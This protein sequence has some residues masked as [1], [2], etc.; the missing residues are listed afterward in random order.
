MIILLGVVLAILLVVFYFL[1]GIRKYAGGYQVKDMTSIDTLKARLYFNELNTRNLLQEI[2]ENP[3]KPIT[4]YDEIEHKIPYKEFDDVVRQIH[5]IGQ[6]KLFLTELQ[7]LTDYLSKFDEKVILVYSGSSPSHKMSY[8]SD[9]FPNLKVVMID[10]N[11]HEV[12]FPNNGSQYQKEYVDTAVYFKCAPGNRFKHNERLINLFDGK[13]VQKHVKRTPESIKNAGDAID[14]ALRSKDTKA[15]VDFIVKSDY[16]YYLIEDLFTD[17]TAEMFKELNNQKEYT[18]LYCSD[19]RSRIETS[20]NFPTDLDILWNSAMQYNWVRIMQP[21]IAMF[22]FRAPYFDRKAFHAVMNNAHKD[23][24]RD[25]FNLAKRNGVDFISDFKNRKFRYLDY[26]SINIQAFAGQNS[27]ETRLIASKKK[28]DGY[29][30]LREIDSKEY[31]DRFFYYN[32]IRRSYGFHNE[33]EEIFDKEIGF[34]ACGDCGL[35]YQLF[36]NYY[37]KFK[38]MKDPKHQIKKDINALINIIRRDFKEAGSMHGYFFKPYRNINT[39]LNEQNYYVLYNIFKENE[40][41]LANAI[42]VE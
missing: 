23:L 37:S 33:H 20:Q 11:E 32:R 4:K 36:K 19:I 31:E 9:M 27:S 39:I 6:L 41:E 25:A 5:H 13:N 12:Y 2:I 3:M 29:K 21:E 10:P 22:K 18:F 17:E 30:K 35:M 15:W 8:L 34:D 16:K 38:N 7:F 1:T 42:I 40:K 24:Y 28:T 26:D 14:K